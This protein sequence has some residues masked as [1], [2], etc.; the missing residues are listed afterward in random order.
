M[1][2]ILVLPVGD[3][4]TMLCDTTQTTE[5]IEL[6]AL[7]HEQNIFVSLCIHAVWQRKCSKAVTFLC[8]ASNRAELMAF[9]NERWF[10]SDKES[11]KE[12]KHAENCSSVS[13][14]LVALLW[15]SITQID[16]FNHFVVQ[17][18]LVYSS[19]SVD[20]CSISPFYCIS[21]RNQAICS[22][23]LLCIFIQ[24]HSPE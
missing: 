15:F 9:V 16:K 21:I 20:L 10:R 1:Y 23:A 12:E 18:L 17:H 2:H 13:N 24:Q 11:R 19:V 6:H 3:S 22:M 7:Q 8:E 5:Q 14:E 4:L